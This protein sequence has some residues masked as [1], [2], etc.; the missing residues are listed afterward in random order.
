M[1]DNHIMVDRFGYAIMP[2]LTPYSRNNVNIEMPI[3][4]HYDVDIIDSSATVIPYSGAAV[5]LKFKT[6][7]G[8]AVMLQLKDNRGQYLPFGT[9]VYNAQGRQLG[10]VGQGG[11]VYLRI[12]DDEE[13][14]VAK[15]DQAQSCT[16]HFPHGEL[17]SSDPLI[18]I[19]GTCQ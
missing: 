1:N 10:L 3:N 14:L 5:K 19:N 18:F 7:S 13:K 4:K 15:I 2:S 6:I 8:K 12:S 9:E 17:T 16:V 11:N